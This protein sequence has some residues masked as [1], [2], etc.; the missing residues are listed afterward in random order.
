MITDT[1]N[2]AIQSVVQ[3]TNGD[4]GGYGIHQMQH[5]S[6]LQQRNTRTI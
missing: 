6:K 3:Q 4:Q 5:S 2:Q 1:E